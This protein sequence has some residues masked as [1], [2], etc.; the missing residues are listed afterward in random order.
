VQLPSYKNIAQAAPIYKSMV[1]TAGT[2]SKASD[3][4]LVYGLGKIMDPNSVVRE[5]EM[6]MVKNTA[7]L[8]DW[9][10]GAANSLNGGAALTPETRAAILKEAHN[11]ITSYK[12]MYD[13]DATHYRGIAR[14]Q[15]G[16][17]GRM[18]SLISASSSLTRQAAAAPSPAAIDDLVKKYS[19]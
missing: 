14:A 17:P 2:N 4:N 18:S 3:L 6:V 7:S 12:T 16:E 19:K 8:P 13:Q 9:L 15:P 10:V 1:E 11:R 5:G